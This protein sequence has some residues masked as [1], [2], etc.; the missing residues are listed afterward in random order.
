MKYSKN[1][2][3]TGKVKKVFPNNIIVVDKNELEYNIVKK[4]ISDKKQINVKSTFKVGEVINFVFLFYNKE[5]NMRYGSFKKNHP[6]FGKN[7]NN[8]MLKATKNG[9]KNLEAFNKATFKKVK[10][11]KN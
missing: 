2:I 10:N 11:D 9:F 1:E 3:I 7:N 4:E 8:F 6:N 5:K